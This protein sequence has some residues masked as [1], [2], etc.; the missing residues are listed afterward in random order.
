MLLEVVMDKTVNLGVSFSEGV[1]TATHRNVVGL[2]L[3]DYILSQAPRAETNTVAE[4][5]DPTPIVLAHIEVIIIAK[6]ETSMAELSIA[7]VLWLLTE[8][9][10]PFQVHVSVFFCV[11]LQ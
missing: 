5:T 10:V 3:R 6:L 9:Q 4:V 11:N 7:T 1:Q 2:Q 8:L